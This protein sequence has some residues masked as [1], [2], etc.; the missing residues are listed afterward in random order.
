MVEISRNCHEYLRM[1]CFSPDNNG[2]DDVID[3][4]NSGARYTSTSI[5]HLEVL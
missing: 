3:S 1:W 2:A 4:F 5:T